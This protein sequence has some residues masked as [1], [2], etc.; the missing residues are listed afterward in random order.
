MLLAE[1]IVTDKG[2]ALPVASPCHPLKVKPDAAVAVRVIAAPESKAVPAG[3]TVTVPP[4]TG[5]T[6]TVKLYWVGGMAAKTA[7]NVLSESIST[8]ATP[9]E[10]VDA[11]IQPVKAYPEA[12]D[13][14]AVTT[15]PA[16]YLLSALSG[17]NDTDPAP[18]GETDVVSL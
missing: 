11:P 13:T 8:A 1:D 12:G 3:L 15:V 7:V 16:A 2:F 6:D 17:T 10:L 4:K 18:A 9:Y 14:D 5:K